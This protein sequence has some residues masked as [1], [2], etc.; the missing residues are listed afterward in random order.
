MSYWASPWSEE[1]V[2]GVVPPEPVRV[3]G[4]LLLPP[5]LGPCELGVLGSPIGLLLMA[6]VASSIFCSLS[7]FSYP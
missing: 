6:W 7:F 4:D 2:E 5:L 3:A 1:A